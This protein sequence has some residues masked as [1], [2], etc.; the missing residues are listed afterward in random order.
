MIS[1]VTTARVPTI[2]PPAPARLSPSRPPGSISGKTENPQM[3]SLFPYHDHCP[4][5]APHGRTGGFIALGGHL[6]PPLPGPPSSGSDSL[7]IL[8][9]DPSQP[10]YSV[11]L[12]L[13]TEGATVAQ[14]WEVTC[15]RSHSPSTTQPES[16][17][18]SFVQQAGTQ[19]PL[20]RKHTVTTEHKRGRHLPSWSL[21]SR[22]GESDAAASPRT[23]SWGHGG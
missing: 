12:R 5:P 13:F 16:F 17:D 23:V 7:P 6:G 20:C 9:R 10:R 21:Q 14:R 2:L 22:A 4:H 8:L 1:A 3:P 15:P 19:L 11:I 18:H